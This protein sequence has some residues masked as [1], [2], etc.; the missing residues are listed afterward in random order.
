M[1]DPIVVTHL[2]LVE[3]PIR[4]KF[5]PIAIKTDEQEAKEAAENHAKQAGVT[6]GEYGLV[7]AMEI[8]E[9]YTKGIGVCD[10]WHYDIKEG[11]S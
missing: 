4:G 8:G 11:W 7:T 2:Y 1:N 3:V 6:E 10:H 9:E 5:Q